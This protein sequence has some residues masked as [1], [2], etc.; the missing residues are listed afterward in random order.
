MR[1]IQKAAGCLLVLLLLAACAAAQS[2]KQIQIGTFVF[3]GTTDPNCGQFCNVGY[4]VPSGN[5][6]RAGQ[7]GVD[8][9]WNFRSCR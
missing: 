8:Q 6:W 3:H 7:I 9:K 5:P 4:K 1:A 2:T